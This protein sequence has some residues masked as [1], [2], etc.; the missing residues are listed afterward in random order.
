MK[1]ATRLPGER[2]LK[3]EDADRIAQ[4]REQ[5]IAIGDE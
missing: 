1:L 4:I 3:T 5:L 2:S